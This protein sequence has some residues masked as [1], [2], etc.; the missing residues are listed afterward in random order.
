MKKVIFYILFAALTIL[1]PFLIVTYAQ[2]V[3]VT[4]N[5]TD[6]GLT[7]SENFS[8]VTN[9]NGRLIIKDRY[10]SGLYAPV[11]D[12]IFFDHTFGHAAKTSIQG[13]SS[14]GVPGIRWDERIG[15][16]QVNLDGPDCCAAGA[17]SAFAASSIEYNSNASPGGTGECCGVNYSVDS[18]AGTGRFAFGYIEYRQGK[19]TDETEQEDGTTASSYTKTQSFYHTATGISGIWSDFHGSVKAPPC[20]PAGPADPGLDTL[21]TLCPWNTGPNYGILVFNEPTP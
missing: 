7:H 12:N 15:T 3:Q 11:S 19:V 13:T 21:L 20:P 6:G 2:E 17:G 8:A 4:V 5:V 16:E 18:P 10:Q 14:F 9:V 1:A